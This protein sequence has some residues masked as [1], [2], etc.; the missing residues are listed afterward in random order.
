MAVAVPLQRNF[1]HP[2]EEPSEAH[3]MAPRGAEFVCG[4]LRR[5]HWLHKEE[6]GEISFDLISRPRVA[7]VGPRLS[8]VAAFAPCL[9]TRAGRDTHASDHTTR[10]PKCSRWGPPGGVVLHEDLRN[11]HM[12][13]TE[14]RCRGLKLN[15]P[16]KLQE[17]TPCVWV[18]NCPSRD[19][20]MS[21]R[22]QTVA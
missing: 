10:T 7:G 16:S 19:F 8:W 13:F 9:Y 4:P 12:S 15:S 14:A 5:C 20:I 6:P 22:P 1:R 3:M 18:L 2:H 17:F 11:V 21:R